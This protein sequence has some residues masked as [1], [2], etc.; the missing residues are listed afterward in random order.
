[1]PAPV[2]NSQVQ[3]GQI[4]STNPPMLSQPVL[5]SLLHQ[6]SFDLP[7]KPSL[8]LSWIRDA[9]MALNAGDPE[10]A[11]YVRPLLTVRPQP[12]DATQ[13][14]ALFLALVS[15]AKLSYSSL[16]HSVRDRISC[17]TL[18]DFRRLWG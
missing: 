12:R 13:G 10:V 14:L 15:S 18:R 9:A 3:A 1:M 7:K 2:I 6:L 5:L 16:S 8:K 11:S 4:L 17:A